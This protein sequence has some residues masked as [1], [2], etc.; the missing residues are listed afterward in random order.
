MI[1][2]IFRICGLSVGIVCFLFFFTKQG[3][4]VLSDIFYAFWSNLW[5][6]KCKHAS[7]FYKN[8]YIIYFKLIMYS[9]TSSTSYYPS[10]Y[11]HIFFHVICDV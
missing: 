4:Y 9:S 1:N 6:Q 5:H 3:Y 10:I 11:M 2:Y 7:Q 8:T